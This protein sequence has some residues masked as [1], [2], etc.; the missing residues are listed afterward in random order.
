MPCGSEGKS[1]MDLRQGS[2]S[3]CSREDALIVTRVLRPG[4][5]A[6]LR[7]RAAAVILATRLRISSLKCAHTTSSSPHARPQTP[8]RA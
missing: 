3:I 1:S 5:Y 7:M 2:G 8:S 4:V 6:G